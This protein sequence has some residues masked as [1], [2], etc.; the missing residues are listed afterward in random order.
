MSGVGHKGSRSGTR[1]GSYW[2]FSVQNDFS[3]D[4]ECDFDVID[5]RTIPVCKSSKRNPVSTRRKM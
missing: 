2:I 5:L 4:F 1:L 3:K